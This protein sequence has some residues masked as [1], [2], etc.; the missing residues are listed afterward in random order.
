MKREITEKKEVK[1]LKGKHSLYAEFC[2]RKKEDV[3][4]KKGEERIVEDC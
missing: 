3:G 2:I 4:F 1:A